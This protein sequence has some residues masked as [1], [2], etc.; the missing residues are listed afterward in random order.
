MSN[1]DKVD[2][3]VFKLGIN[4]NGPEVY[5]R[6]VKKELNVKSSIEKLRNRIN[7][8]N[9]DEDNVHVFIERERVGGYKRPVN[10]WTT[11][12]DLEDNLIVSLTSL[13][14]VI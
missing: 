4:P 1:L 12:A 11:F 14:L 6:K 10:I 3:T 13:V 2:K 8:K 7:D 5:S 9:N